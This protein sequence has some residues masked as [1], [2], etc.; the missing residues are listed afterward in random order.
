MNPVRVLLLADDPLT[1]SGLH[2]LL[3]G[4][5]GLHVM[6]PDLDAGAADVALCD[7]S[8]S[9][10]AVLPAVAGAP[11]LALVPDDGS[12]IR[13][14]R[15]GARGLL[16]RAADPA[17]LPAALRAVAQGLLV[18]DAA[19]GPALLQRRAAEAPAEALSRREREVL[20][21]LGQGLSN[22]LIADRLGISD[23]TAKFHVTALLEKLGATTRTE[24]VMRAARLGLLT[25]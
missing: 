15:Q 19:L 17:R 24:A 14:L 12:A 22:K 7:L 1:R 8:S 3:A 5:P 9:P 11:L 13:A 2:A 16:L 18:L 4:D 23:H 20:E 25:I 10:S 6:S 21:L